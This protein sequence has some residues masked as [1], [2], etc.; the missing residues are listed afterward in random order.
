MRG[1]L[2]SPALGSSAMTTRETFGSGVPAAVV[3]ALLAGAVAV[4]LQPVSAMS[5]IAQHAAMLMRGGKGILSPRWSCGALGF[6]AHVI[7]HGIKYREGLDGLYRSPKG[8]VKQRHT[9]SRHRQLLAGAVVRTYT[10]PQTLHLSWY[11]IASPQGL[12]R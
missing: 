3:V 1:E 4:L 8:S 5:V 9:S 11:L 10:A 12:K 2:L 6:A 7:L